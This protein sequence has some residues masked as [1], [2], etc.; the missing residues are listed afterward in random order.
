LSSWPA[1]RLRREEVPRSR[2]EMQIR[3]GRKIGSAQ[4]AQDQPVP[5]SYAIV[6]L[7]PA[8]ASFDGGHAPKKFGG[9]HRRI[10]M[11]EPVSAC[12]QARRFARRVARNHPMN[13]QSLV[14]GKQNN[15]SRGN[16]IE[17]STLNGN[18]IAGQHRR[19][20]TRSEDAKTNLAK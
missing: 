9:S 8:M 5:T 6:R 18:Q 19:R 14:P 16:L 20:H 4:H 13:E 2:E 15:L 7:E 3:A 10:F 17:F 12:D 11:A 1:F